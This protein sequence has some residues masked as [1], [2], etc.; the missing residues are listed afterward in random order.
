MFSLACFAL[1]LRRKKAIAGKPMTVAINNVNKILLVSMVASNCCGDNGKDNRA[2]T[3]DLNMKKYAQ[4][5]LRVHHIVIPR[6]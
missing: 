6:N 5:R 4:V 2:G 1:L 3:I